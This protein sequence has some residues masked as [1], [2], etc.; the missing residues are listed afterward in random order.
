MLPCKAS[1]LPP[2]VGSSRNL[3]RVFSA[4]GRYLVGQQVPICGKQFLV[5]TPTVRCANIIMIG[6]RKAL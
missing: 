4:A 3:V 1:D 6:E 2:G 5:P